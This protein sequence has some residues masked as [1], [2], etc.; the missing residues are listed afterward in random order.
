MDITKERILLELSRNDN[1]DLIQKQV[2]EQIK[3]DST[4]NISS[5]M[6]KLFFSVIEL[7]RDIRLSLKD[8]DFQ[9]TKLKLADIF[10]VLISVCNHLN[11]NLFDCLT[12]KEDVLKGNV[13][14]WF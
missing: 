4:S 7:S 3:K 13:A 5:E 11:I 1:L 10:L 14:K 2:L 8:Q 6:F 12:Y 9:N